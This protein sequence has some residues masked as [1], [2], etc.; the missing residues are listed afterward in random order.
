MRIL[1]L[2]ISAFLFFVIIVVG[3]FFLL[4]EVLLFWGA[5]NI[6]GSLREMVQARNRGS[7][8]TQCSALGSTPVGTE[9]L[10]T[11]QVRFLTSSE[12]LVEAVCQGFDYDP[13]LI[14]QGSLPQFVTKV[15]GTSGFLD[16]FTATGIEL[17]VFSSES[18]A[19]S[20]TTGFDFSFLV[21]QKLLLAEEG[22]LIKAEKDA[23]MGEGPVTVCSGY[24]YEC[25]NEVSHFGIG[26]RITGL[27]DCENS[28][29][30]ACASRPVV[31]SF[32]SNPL[33]DPKTRTVT[34]NPG[35]PVQFTYV[36]DSGEAKSMSG[37]LD[38][39][40][41]EKAPISGLAGQVSH[42]YECAS[43]S[44]TYT[45]VVTLEDNWGA[46]SADLQNNKVTIL[47]VR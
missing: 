47:V 34:I 3:G 15:P 24:G 16:S 44:C 36:A 37:I 12:Y 31:L 27:S 6:K 20:N 28:C 11:Y 7:F 29:Y 45:A 42:T 21:K 32:N 1:R 23:F 39:G 41:G 40:D 35:D 5:S 8:G 33:M 14:A 25:C 2:L 18:K 9:S 17:E 38:F 19:L 30:A 4:R 46:K 22:V 10:V 26:D 43:S 13:I